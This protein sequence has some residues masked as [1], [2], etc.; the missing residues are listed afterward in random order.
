VEAGAQAAEAASTAQA[1][2]GAAQT[3]DP[4][5]APAT[6]DTVRLLVEEYNRL[7]AQPRQRTRTAELDRLFGAMVAIVPRVP[8]SD[9]VK[10]L[11]ARD[12]GTRL[13]GY[14]YLYG[15]PDPARLN[16]VVDAL[17]HEQTPFNQYWVIRTVATLM[18]QSDVSTLPDSVFITLREL[19]DRLPADT[20]RHAQLAELLQSRRE[21]LLNPLSNAAL[22]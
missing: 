8:D 11:Q 3:F 1:A 7:R 5:A 21:A 6:M 17:A 9:L 10:A 4:T 15:R 22:R 14:A 19:M 13:T 2:F 18:E 12:D 16:D 20:S